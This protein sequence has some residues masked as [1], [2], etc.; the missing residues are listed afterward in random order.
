MSSHVLR[1]FLSGLCLFALAVPKALGVQ[2][3]ATATAATRQAQREALEPFQSLVGGW[4]GVGQPRRGSNVGAWSETAEWIW[5]LKDE[6]GPALC[7]SFAEGK[8]L[9]SARL[10]WD[11]REE[12][13]VLDGDYADNTSRRFTGRR[14]GNRLVLETIADDETTHQVTLTLLNEKRTL[15]LYQVRTAKGTQ[16]N[17]VAEVGYTRAGTKLAE[18]GI[19]GRE[20]IVTG[21]LGS[22]QVEY[23]GKSYWVCCTGCREAFL[24]DPDG[25]LAE[26]AARA[27]KRP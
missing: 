19:T 23:R 24:D 17:R 20:C 8:Q 25:I 2:E 4:R 5:D 9:R 15:L 14:N 1:R 13:Y 10:R 26:A 27:K 21:G 6:Q 16:F 12:Q 3:P 22:I 7:V 18:E 11:P